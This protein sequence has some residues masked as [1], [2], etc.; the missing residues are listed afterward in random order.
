MSVP[1]RGSLRLSRRDLLV[2][3]AACGLVAGCGDGAPTGDLASGSVDGVGTIKHDYERVTLAADDASLAEAVDVVA[4]GDMAFAAKLFEA[5][6]MGA[7]TNV[8]FS[9]YS[10]SAALSMVLAGAAGSTRSQLAEALGMGPDEPAW[11]RGRNILDQILT[12]PSELPL[13]VEPEHDGPPPPTVELANAPFID[14]SA[15]IL[16]GFVQILAEQYGAEPFV[17]EFDDSRKAT[18]TINEWVAEQTDGR[19]TD[20]LPEGSLEPDT[21]LTLVNTVYF[22]AYWRERFYETDTVDRTFTRLDASTVK[23]PMMS[24]STSLGSVGD[25]WTASSLEYSNGYEMLIIVPDHDRLAD[26]ERIIAAE[27]TGP[28]VDNAAVGE[29]SVIIPRFDFSTTAKADSALKA[30]GIL[31]AFNPTRADFSRITEP[32]DIYIDGVHHQ[33]NITVNEEGTVASA[34]TAVKFRPVSGL[35]GGPSPIEVHADKPFV[36]AIRHSTTGSTLFLGRVLDPT[37]A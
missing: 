24:A 37:A 19:I 26:V 20:L 29:F 32:Q 15:D 13:G 8:V 28:F 25:Y 23:A 1:D 18:A 3:L 31:D 17:I 6:A 7:D 22:N 30:L 9:P 4:E 35:I 36:F 34:A 2:A 14:V 16:D 5:L 12:A 11:H 21:V 33:A 27:G 10:I